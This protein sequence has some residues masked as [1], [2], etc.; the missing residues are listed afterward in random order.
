MNSKRP[1]PNFMTRLVEE[2][3]DLSG[4]VLASG[5]LVVHDTGRGGEDHVTELTGRKELD[6]PLL[7][8]TETDVVTRGDDTGLVETERR[9]SWRLLRQRR[10]LLTGRSAE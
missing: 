1:F 4:D 2:T 3:D 10:V 8:I 5:L 7:E 6:N 9:V